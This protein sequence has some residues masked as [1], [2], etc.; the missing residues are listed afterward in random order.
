MLML[1]CPGV[2]G[3]WSWFVR[4]SVLSAIM[5]CAM[6]PSLPNL[7]AQS[8]PSAQGVGADSSSS[9]NRGLPQDG[10]VFDESHAWGH[11]ESVC[12]MGQRYST[13]PGMARQIDYLEANLKS[14]VDKVER[15]DFTAP[16]PDNGTPVTLTNLIASHR[17]ER[18]SRL[19]FC[20]HYDTR[21]WPDRDPVNPRGVFV[22]AND[23]GSGVAV[24]TEMA[25]HMDAIDGDLGVDF[26]FFD[27]EEFV[28]NGRRDPMFLGSTHFATEYARRLNSGFASATP[29][30]RYVAA[31]LVDMVGDRDLQLFYEG[32]SLKYAGELTRSIWSVASAMQVSEF[33]P[34]RRHELR[35]DHLPLNQIAR[36]PTCDIIDFDFPNPRRKLAYWHTEKD[37]LENCSQK[38]LGIVGRVLLEWTRQMQN[39]GTRSGVR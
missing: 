6:L 24:L 8:R 21:P 2:L 3:S 25:R 31:V 28:L 10:G 12:A 14:V 22:G 32:N 27:G 39:P 16:R 15:Q 34:R 29:P 18:V 4:L 37:T 7:V 11:L 30:P 19:L 36:I 9:S 33:I 20:C 35:D 5:V 23:G 13:S 26:V 17:P 1:K 38:S